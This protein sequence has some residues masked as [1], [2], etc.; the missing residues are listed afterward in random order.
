M[1]CEEEMPED[2]KKGRYYPKLPGGFR[3]TPQGRLVFYAMMNGSALGWQARILDIKDEVQG[4]WWYWHPYK[5]Q[6]VG[7][8]YF[9]RESGSWL[10]Y[11]EFMGRE[12]FR[13]DPSKYRT[14]RGVSRSAMLMG[15]DAAL[16]WNASRPMGKKVAGI[17]EGPLDAA[18]AGPPFMPVLGKAF[19]V[20]QARLVAGSFDRVIVVGDSDEGGWL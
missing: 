9:D 14:S 8:K 10:F 18:R 16:Q 1:W 4:V 13:F 3:D 19:S 7:V 20:E 15:F 17:C 6:W 5:R 2:P 11:P 12:G